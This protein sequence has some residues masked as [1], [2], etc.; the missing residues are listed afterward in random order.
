[1][2]PP[3]RSLDWTRLFPGRGRRNRLE[4][5]LCEATCFAQ[6]PVGPAP[7]P[8]LLPVRPE[9]CFAQEV[10]APFSRRG[11]A[12]FSVLG[13][14]RGGLQI[15]Q[16][17]RLLVGQPQNQVVVVPA[18][19]QGVLVVLRQRLHLRGGLQ[20]Q[21]AGLLVLALLEQAHGA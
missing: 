18:A 13:R 15:Q 2:V 21:P 16:R 19:G 7:C 20:R 9:G 14:R 1:T 6:A 5:R 4:T 10:P 11:R 12:S 8:H 17:P 3:V